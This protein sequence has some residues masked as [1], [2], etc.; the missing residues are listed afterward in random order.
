MGREAGSSQSRSSLGLLGTDPI[1]W[2]SVSRPFSFPVRLGTFPAGPRRFPDG[3]REISLFCAVGNCTAKSLQNSL[4]CE[5]RTLND[6]VLRKIPCKFPVTRKNR[7]GDGFATDYLHSQPVRVLRCTPFGGRERNAVSETYGWGGQYGR[8]LCGRTSH[9]TGP[10]FSAGSFADMLAYAIRQ[11]GS[12][13]SAPIGLTIRL[14]APPRVV[15]SGQRSP[16][17]ARDRLRDD[18]VL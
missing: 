9:E 11:A 2:F 6:D 1:D 18:K 8:S 17:S 15:K 4:I 7:P 16:G 12:V 10:V 5:R 14:S 13:V 3:P